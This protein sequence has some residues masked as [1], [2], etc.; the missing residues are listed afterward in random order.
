MQKYAP[1]SGPPEACQK[2]SSR[3]RAAG[4]GNFAFSTAII[5]G[6]LLL[7]VPGRAFAAGEPAPVLPALVSE[8]T[9][10]WEAGTFTLTLKTKLP[11]D[12]ESTPPKRRFLAEQEAERVVQQEFV[13]QAAKLP[14][15]SGKTLGELMAEDPA[16][17]AGVAQLGERLRFVSSRVDED[18]TALEMVWSAGLWDQLG[19]VLT[20]P[21]EPNPVPSLVKWAPSRDFSGLVVFAMGDLPWKGTGLKARW[22]PSLRF[23]LLNPQGEVVFDP[24]MADPEYV[25]KWGQAGTS[26]GRFNEERWRDRIGFDP[27]RIVARGVWGARPGDLILSDSDWDRILSR[28][29]NR[30][31]LAEGRVLILY[32]PFPDYTVSPN[33]D[34]VIDES[35][36]PIEEIPQPPPPSET[37][38]GH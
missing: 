24:T 15:A 25:L 20:D 7:F 26:L 2:V 14:A 23:R 17:E 21:A 31:L 22:E 16:V 8:G 18:Y 13:R 33:P 27:L 38:A 32:G 3:R 1:V 28:E 37:Q 35:L 4:S 11:A 19:P 34:S 6:L 12:G 10:D 9:W 36:P 30:R 29:A 5:S